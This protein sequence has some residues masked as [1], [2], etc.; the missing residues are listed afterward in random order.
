MKCNHVIIVVLKQG[1]KVYDQVEIEE[2]ANFFAPQI[3]GW[4]KRI[5]AGIHIFWMSRDSYLKKRVMK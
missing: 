5:F 1:G 2:M 4:K 3:P